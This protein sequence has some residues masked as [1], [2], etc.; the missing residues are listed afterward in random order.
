MRQLRIEFFSVPNEGKRSKI[1]G[2]L[3]KAM[4]LRP[5]AVDMVLITRPPAFPDKHAV[6]EF[7]T[8]TGRIEPEQRDTHAVMRGEGWVVI[9]PRTIPEFHDGLKLLGFVS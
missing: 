6:F 2:A 8:E 7:K 5:G 1:T 4:G 3:L 9:V